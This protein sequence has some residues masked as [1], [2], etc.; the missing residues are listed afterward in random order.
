MGICVSKVVQE[1]NQVKDEESKVEIEKDKGAESETKLSPLEASL[2]KAEKRVFD[3]ASDSLEGRALRRWSVSHK[4]KFEEE[5]R[6]RRRSS[7]AKLAKRVSSTVRR[8]SRTVL[9]FITIPTVS[10]NSSNV[11]DEA[12]CG[13]KES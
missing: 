4:E 9:N 12:D 8:A 11:S 5:E 6:E 10:P 13:F 1:E 7:I 3:V 2:L